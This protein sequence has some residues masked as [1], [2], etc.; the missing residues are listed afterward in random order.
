[1]CDVRARAAWWAAADGGR[2]GRW[3]GARQVAPSKNDEP[4]VCRMINVKKDEYRKDK[5]RRAAAA[6][7]KVMMT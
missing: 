3:G 6:E 2:G 7:L 5:L 4:P 1:V